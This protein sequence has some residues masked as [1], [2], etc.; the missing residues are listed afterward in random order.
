MTWTG[1]ALTLRLGHEGEKPNRSSSSDLGN[2]RA[3]NAQQE[4]TQRRGEPW[5]AKA[6]TAKQE[7]APRRGGAW[8]KG[9]E[10]QAGAREGTQCTC[11]PTTSGGGAACTRTRE[12]QQTATKSGVSLKTPCRGTCT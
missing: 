11:G 3:K 1:G 9:P 5:S 6:Q 4:P 12:S 2:A 10:R 7:P 8:D